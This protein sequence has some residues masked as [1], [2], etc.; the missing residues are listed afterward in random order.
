M[1][2]TLVR[3][4]LCVVVAFRYIIPSFVLLLLGNKS[5]EWTR[6]VGGPFGRWML[7]A[8]GAKAEFEGLENLDPSKTYVFVGNHQSYVDIF[9]VF[10]S[11]DA[12]GMRTLFM[13]KRELEK[14]PL[15]GP[16]IWAMG[17]IPIERGET[18]QQMATMFESVKT[19]DKGYSLTIFAEGSRT[20]DGELQP[21][22]RGAFLLAEQTGKEIV[23]FVITGSFN[24][25]PRNKFRI[26]SG[27]CKIS[28]QKPIPPGT[29]K[30]KELMAVVEK[31]IGELY[32]V[33]RVETEAKWSKI[34]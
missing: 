32:A 15:F 25:F 30:S 24:I 21:F 12:K 34:K 1:I 22:K 3:F 26:R 20:Y 10:A 33:Q 19:L 23:P 27:P 11:L 4:V 7:K 13:A 14:I 31:Q 5:G 18:R 16:V 8:C 17:L 28:F 9:L 6:S 2:Q 29:M